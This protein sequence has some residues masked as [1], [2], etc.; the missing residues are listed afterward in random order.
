[1][2]HS[3]RKHPDEAR[4]QAMRDEMQFHV[5]MEAE[6]LQR[7]GVPADE[8]KRRALASFGGMRRYAEE[9]NDARRGNWREDLRRDVRYSLRSL[10]RTPG[11]TFVVIFTLALAIAANTSIFSIANSVLFKQ[12]PY[13]DPSRL[14][15]LWDGLD[16]VGVP[17]A[18]TTGPEVV[19]LRKELTSFEG[20]SAVRG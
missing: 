10:A 18:W 7:M 3:P 19:R 5:E 4:E 15:V 1:M 14:M 8:A 11:Y 6:E 17:E 2:T 16:W 20:F 9:A 13:R 12:L